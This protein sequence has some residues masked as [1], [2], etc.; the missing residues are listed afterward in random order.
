MKESARLN[1]TRIRIGLPP[2]VNIGSDS[3][4][5]PRMQAIRSCV[6][7]LEEAL[8]DNRDPVIRLA[9]RELRRTIGDRRG[10][11]RPQ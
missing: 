5:E 6:D 10:F 9:L 3:A 2:L 1:L 8:Q 11:T 4:S 7:T